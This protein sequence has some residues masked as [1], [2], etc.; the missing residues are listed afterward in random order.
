MNQTSSIPANTSFTMMGDCVIM[1]DRSSANTQLIFYSLNAGLTD[2]IGLAWNEAGGFVR[3]TLTVSDAG[4]VTSRGE[5]AWRPEQ[6]RPF[7]WYVKCSGT[8]TGLVKA[9]W[10]YPGQRW[11]ETS[12]TLG[13]TIAAPTTIYYGQLASTLWNHKKLQNLKTWSRPLSDIEIL[14]ESESYEPLA[15]NGLHSWHPLISATNVNDM[16]GL[17]RNLTVTNC[18]TSEFFYPRPLRSAPIA[19]ADAPASTAF[20]ILA[21]LPFSLAGAHGLAGD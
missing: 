18:T 3:G 21:G 10:R 8:G 12:A 1:F 16:S 17:G 14:Q 15:K 4:A 9:G 6:N 19:V 7:C 11:V 20:Q 13:T 5:F 2:G